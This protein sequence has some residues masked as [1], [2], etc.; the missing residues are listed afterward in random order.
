V[1]QRRQDVQVR[2]PARFVAEPGSRNRRL[3]PPRAR[4]AFA[5]WAAWY[6]ARISSSTWRSLPRLPRRIGGSAGS[7][8]TANSSA[9]RRPAGAVGQAQPVLAERVGLAAQGGLDLAAERTASADAHS[10]PS[11]GFGLRQPV[12]VRRMPSAPGGPS[13]AP[14][15]ADRSSSSGRSSKALKWLAAL[16]VPSRAQASTASA[17]AS[18]SSD[19]RAFSPRPNWL[20]T[21][22]MASG[23]ARRSRRAAG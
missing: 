2:Q 8:A 1:Q 4:R 10:P 16:F 19:S 7:S 9:R 23:R 12:R 13:T 17:A 15:G 6:A 21:W 14:G 20:R 11:G 22:S 3:A 18:S 5:A